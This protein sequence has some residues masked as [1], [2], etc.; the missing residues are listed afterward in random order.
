MA[1]FDIKHLIILLISTDIFMIIACVY[2]VRK[3]RLIPKIEKFEEGI[4]IFESLLSDADQ[5]SE[6][7]SEEIKKKYDT[8]K[9]ISTELDRRID[10]IN[11][12]LNRADIILSHNG[13][14]DVQADQPAKSILLKQKEIVELD[15]KGCDVE[16]IANRLLIPKG[17]VKLILDL[18]KKR[19][20]LI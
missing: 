4:K 8:I 3:I 9:N 5:A 12:L 11:M 1:I 6:N 10:S 13:K 18:N 17:E 14:K 20:D 19:P 7:F 16:E 2:L 15:D